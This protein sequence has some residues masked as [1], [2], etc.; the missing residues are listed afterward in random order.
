MYCLFL[1]FFPFIALMD[2]IKR[3]HRKKLYRICGC[4]LPTLVILVAT[5]IVS[6]GIFSHLPTVSRDPNTIRPLFTTTGDGELTR[7]VEV[8]F[9]VNPFWIVEADFQINECGGSALI[10][11]GLKC[12]DLSVHVI[13]STMPNEFLRYLYLLPGSIVNITVHDVVNDSELQVWSFNAEGWLHNNDPGLSCDSPPSGSNCFYA[14]KFA[15]QTLTHEIDKADFYFFLSLDGG[16]SRDVEFT[17]TAIQYN[18]TAI[19]KFYRP[20]ETSITRDRSH[21]VIISS[22][23][24]FQL[25]KCVLLTSL[26][27]NSQNYAVVINNVKR[28]M[29]VLIFQ[30]VIGLALM[31]VG[32]TTIG[33]CTAWL[34]WSKMKNNDNGAVV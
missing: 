28:R 16:S 10:T 24:D 8:D 23:F 14:R 6:L 11:D 12:H 32:M 9:G 25:N 22:I 5:I 30:G 20:V 17:Y 21:T 1:V 34:V 19:R 33:S 13:E 2:I 3:E 27:L 18:L 7:V 15:G 29:D 26:C 31:V 4:F